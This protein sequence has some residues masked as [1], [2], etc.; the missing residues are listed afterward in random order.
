MKKTYPYPSLLPQLL[1]LLRCGLWG[2]VPD[3]SRFRGLTSRQWFQLLLLAQQ[4]SV[5]G[6]AADAVSRLPEDCMP[7]AD[8]NLQWFGYHRAIRSR[9]RHFSEIRNEVLGW[10]EAAG[11]RCA[12][13]K[14]DT[15]NA[16]YPVPG[17]RMNG[18]VDLW[19]PDADGVQRAAELLN[20]KGHEV[21]FPGN[22]HALFTYRDVSFELHHDFLN[23]PMKVRVPRTLVYTDTPIFRGWQLNVE[24]KTVML[25]TH[26]AHHF[27]ETGL[28]LRHLC[29]WTVWLYRYGATPE[30]RRG[31][32]EIRR[33]G[34]SVFLTEFTTMAVC[35]LG[36]EFP[37]YKKLIY[38]SLPSRR[39]R[40]LHEMLLQGNLGKTH[41]QQKRRHAH[42]V[43]FYLHSFLRE[44]GLSVFWPRYVLTSIPHQVVRT[45]GM[46]R[47]K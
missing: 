11:I 6:L 24:A 20:G 16:L 14:G 46:L 25:L 43:F 17:L 29:D 35:L 22:H 32:A 5:V 34:A 38:R 27:I 12:V 9:Q 41:L 47:G 1:E 21:R 37:D 45:L 18:D 7:P 44:L 33:I 2:T 19:F 23:L 26:A 15:V 13:F 39:E 30:A 3:A 4:Q 10:F 36:L 40:L 28:G 31:L 8:L 42:L